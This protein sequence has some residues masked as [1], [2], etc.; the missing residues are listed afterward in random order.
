M[1]AAAPL[2]NRLDEI[3][4]DRPTPRGW[5][6]TVYH[7]KIGKRYRVTAMIFLLIGGIEALLMRMQ[8]AGPWLGLLS[9]EAYNQ[10]MSMTERPLGAWEDDG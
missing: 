10:F 6:A 2:T 9:S 7:K 5:L 4:S 3:W 1:S 8:L